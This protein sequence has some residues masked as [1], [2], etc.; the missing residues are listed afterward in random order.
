MTQHHDL[1]VAIVGYGPTG[2]IAALTLARYGI[3]AVAFERD[4]DIHPRARAV[5]VNDWTMRIFQLEHADEFNR[6]VTDFVV[7]N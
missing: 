6:L 2:V 7:D 5:T 1:D 3:S 4:R